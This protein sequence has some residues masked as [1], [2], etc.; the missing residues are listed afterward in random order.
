MSIIDA[1]GQ[2]VKNI[3]KVSS[4]G[5]N[6]IEWD[7]YSERG[8]LCASGV[9]YFLITIGEEKFGKKLILIK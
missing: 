1:S 6:F 5:E 7:G 4:L 9:Y 3:S 8:F 2:V